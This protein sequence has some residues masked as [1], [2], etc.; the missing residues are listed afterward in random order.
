M[1]IEIFKKEITLN[2]NNKGIKFFLNN[3]G[4]SIN[5]IT[6]SYWYSLRNDDIPNKESA[7]IMRNMDLKSLTNAILQNIYVCLTCYDFA[8]EYADYVKDEIKQ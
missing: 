2:E 7:E 3:M 4:I 1:K 6:M 5:E 8:K